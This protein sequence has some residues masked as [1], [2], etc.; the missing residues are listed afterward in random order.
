[1]KLSG[2]R[3]VRSMNRVFG[4]CLCLVLIGLATAG[5]IAYTNQSFPGRTL[6]GVQI[7][8]AEPLQQNEV[9]YTPSAAAGG[10]VIQVFKAEPM[11]LATA[12]A[13][14]V[15]TFKVKRATNVVINEAGAN[16]KNISNPSGAALSGTANG[17]PASAITTDASGKF[18]CTIAASNDN[19]TVTKALELSLA[20]E[21]LPPPGQ[22]GE[23]GRQT[24]NDKSKWL[25]QLPRSI[26][27]TSIQ[28]Y[29]NK[30]EPNFFKCPTGCENCLK[31][32]DAASLGFTQKCSEELCYYSPDN[33][34]KW[35]C[36]KPTPGWC[37]ANEKVSQSTKSECDKIQGYWST[38]QADATQ[39]CQPKGF[40]CLNGQVYYPSTQA[41]CV[42]MG[43]TNWS[44][45][46]D[47]TTRLC[48]PPGYCCLNGHI[49]T[50]TQTQCAQMGGSNWSTNQGQTA[51][52]CRP[53]TC[54]CCLKGQ[55]Y[56]TTQAQCS[57][58]GGACYAT[59]SQA[60]AACRQF[61]DTGKPTTPNLR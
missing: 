28:S 17:M 39:A 57:Q 8:Q 23:T 22:S 10:P 37:C 59:Q 60:I 41:Q 31:P 54:W 11:E 2:F 47:Q 42:Q 61:T 38:S 49:T 43:G 24:G 19:G 15:Y 27:S 56:Q 7:A 45:N 33:Q 6:P 44:T 48:Q 26:P 3:W 30:N 40:C 32:A 25:D 20:K 21:L 53:Q 18:T 16:I 5:A 58:S 4:L 13:S 50:A 12:D 35:Y 14:A 1:M 9:D 46:Q 52:L 55:V 34:Q 51:E 36:Y 29:I